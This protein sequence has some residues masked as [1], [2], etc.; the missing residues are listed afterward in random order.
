MVELYYDFH[1]HSCLS[2]CGDEDMTPRNI[3]GMAALAGYGLIAAADHNSMRNCRAVMEAGAQAGLLVV[4]AMELCTREEVHV[5]CFLPDL[6]SADAF[7]RYV[8]EKLP[9]IPNRVDI[10]GGQVCMDENDQVLGQ[11]EKLLI[12][13]ADIGV[14]EVYG[15][16][17]SYGGTAVP[18][19][20]DRQAFSLISNLG[21]YDP[22][23]Q[24]P[25]VELTADCDSAVFLQA[26]QIVLPYIVDSD[27][28]TLD[29]MPDPK[30]KIRLND[31]SVRGVIEAI[32]LSREEAG[33]LL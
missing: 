22:A 21:F 23:M 18:A 6:E 29:Q 28:H 30:R 32:E 27:A 1:L 4:P 14:Y 19:H 15:L 26:H 13:A 31:P 9:D 5:L 3:A 12:S 33:I 11:V 8:Y 16:V 10:F 20:L 7:D 25:A 17:K 24:F 2:P